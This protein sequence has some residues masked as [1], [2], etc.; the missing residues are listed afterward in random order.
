MDEH[1]PEGGGVPAPIPA[2]PEVGELTSE[3]VA[4]DAP[5]GNAAVTEAEQGGQQPA[6]EN[7][8]DLFRGTL[9]TGEPWTQRRYNRD[10][11]TWQG[12]GLRHKRHERRMGKI[13]GHATVDLAG[14]FEPSPRPGERSLGTRPVR[15][16]LIMVVRPARVVLRGAP[17]LAERDS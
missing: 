1:V 2:N 12:A 16:F 9:P 15:Y 6:P 4:R 5:S 11:I 7:V 17:Q 14:P 3:A 13:L 10:N 8:T